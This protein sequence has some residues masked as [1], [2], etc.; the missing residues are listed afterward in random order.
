MD[1]PRDRDSFDGVLIMDATTINHVF[2]HINIS[3][4]SHLILFSIIHTLFGETS[5]N[6]SI[7][8][9]EYNAI[10]NLMLMIDQTFH[11]S[12]DDPEM[13][14]PIWE[15]EL[16]RLTNNL[17]SHLPYLRT[18]IQEVYANITHSL[19]KVNHDKCSFC[20][21]EVDL[22]AEIVKVTFSIMR[23]QHANNHR[24]INHRI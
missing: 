3:E 8:A 19:V 5:D 2:D 12:S 15:S 9:A 11:E 4:S 21:D 13:F 17:N 14:D 22:G 16:I 23:F 24:H 10:E 20:V 7:E 18:I 6:P 1:Y